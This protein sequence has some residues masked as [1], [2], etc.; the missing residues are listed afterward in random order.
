[1][2][3]VSGFGKQSCTVDWNM[4]FVLFLELKVYVTFKVEMGPD[5]K[6]KQQFYN[7]FSSLFLLITINHFTTFIKGLI[8]KTFCD[9]LRFLYS[10]N[11]KYYY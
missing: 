9:G 4:L 3:G 5:K 10:V 8:T 1:M 6:C 2:L 11:K 7:H